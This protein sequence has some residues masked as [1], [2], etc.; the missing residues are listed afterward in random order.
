YFGHVDVRVLDGGLAAWDGPLEQ[1]PPLSKQGDFEGTPGHL[2]VLDADDAARV[3]KEGGLVDVRAAERYRGETEPVDPVAGRVPGAINVPATLTMVD[4]RLR[5]PDELRAL[6]PE[7]CEL[8]VYCG[9]GVTAAHGVLVLE[10]LGV[11]AA[12][13]AGSFSQWISDPNR[14]VETG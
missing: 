10:T 12:L 8:G 6:Y 9:S 2:P 13:Y 1:G 7:G 11:Q 14:P 5:S 3:A 4:G